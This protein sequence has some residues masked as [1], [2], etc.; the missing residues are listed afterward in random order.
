MYKNTLFNKSFNRVKQASIVAQKHSISTVMQNKVGLSAFYDKKYVL[1][2]GIHSR[3]YG[4]FM[5]N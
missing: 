1:D 2:D 5:D 4:H 3:S